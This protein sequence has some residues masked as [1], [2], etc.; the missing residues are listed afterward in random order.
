MYLRIRVLFLLSVMIALA[1]GAARAQTTLYWSGAAFDP[2]VGGAGTW[3]GTQQWSSSAGS[4]VAAAWTPGV[5]AV[6][7]GSSAGTISA[8]GSGV[9]GGTLTVQQNYTLDTAGQ[10]LVFGSLVFGGAA[11]NLTVAGG[12]GFSAAISSGTVTLAGA[13]TQLKIGST[14][15]LTGGTVVVQDSAK[16]TITGR[17]SVGGAVALQLLDAGSVSLLGGGL[18]VASLASSADSVIENGGSR[19]S[20]LTVALTS[21]TMTYAG[22]FRDSASGPQAIG[23][24]RLNKQGAG[25]LVLA[26]VA[27]TH[28]GGTMVSEGTLRMGAAGVLPSAGAVTLA[29][30]TLDLAGYDQSVAM[31]SSDMLGTGGQVLLGAG[32]LTIAA[33]GTLIDYRGTIAGTGG[34][35]KSGSGAQ[36]FSGNNSYSGGT[37][38]VAGTLS[39]GHASAL[40]SGSVTV[41]NGATLAIAT[42]STIARNLAL[43]SG[44][45]TL[46]NDPSTFSVTLSGVLSGAATAH[47]AGSSGGS[48]TVSGN[49]TYSGGTKVT[50]ATLTVAADSALG[51][52]AGGILLNNATLGW[53][54]A[55]NLAATRSLTVT[56]Y[57]SLALNG[58]ATTLAQNIGGTGSLSFGTTGTATLT[59]SNSFSGGL[60][61][62]TAT[63]AVDS[64][65]AL[66]AAAGT[67]VIGTSGTLRFRQS[68]NVPAARTIRTDGFVANL[69]V[70]AGATVVL[71]APLASNGGTSSVF[72]KQGA[73]T[74]DLAAISTRTGPT[75]VQAGTLRLSGGDNVLPVGRPL[76]VQSSGTL[77][78]A[79]HSQT[80]SSVSDYG[81]IA[82]GGG[83]FI[84]TGSSTFNGGFSGSGLVRTPGG[85]TYATGDWSNFTGRF[86]LEAGTLQVSTTLNAASTVAISSGAQ[87]KGTGTAGGVEVA[88]GGIV[89]PGYGVGTLRMQDLRVAG[90]ALYR[91]EMQSSDV[92]IAPVADRVRL[93]G[94][95]QLDST[96]GAPLV[97]QVQSLTPFGTAGVVAGFDPAQNYRFTLVTTTGGISGFTGS[98]VALDFS[99]FANAHPGM[100]RVELGNA[101]NDLELA[102]YATTFDTW[103]TQHFTAQ[104]L[105]DPAISGSNADPDGD[106]FVNLIEYALNLN[107]RSDSSVNAP[108]ATA[109]ATDWTFTYTRPADRPDLAYTVQRSTDLV[110]WS[111]AGVTS[112]LVST[113]DGIQ[114]WSAAYPISSSPVCF[115]RL[116]VTR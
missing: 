37:T 95:L 108:A 70:D 67:V 53:S 23:N 11:S 109:T 82:L 86:Q 34:V 76:T 15:S 116:A 60:N 40:G 73:G 111:S 57:S 72:Q 103:L 35:V 50:N 21:G 48:F 55:F 63:V 7:G 61:I 65:A 31:L 71:N 56:G 115:F 27:K 100:F 58:Q 43:E 92:G 19:A 54:G 93:S 33:G 85:G 36:K 110:N 79:G 29:S 39:V 38:V 89:N 84:V 105:A 107:P 18:T 6:L 30:G 106:G 113:S 5:N 1:S 44:E 91:W 62:S 98:N 80:V 99:S 22:V 114:T 96:S 20:V 13:G 81:T 9:A 42:N 10:D 4:Y 52:A 88:S 26:G 102:Y 28:T 49:N 2:A 47:F 74:L 25:T 66:G 45:V 24:L 32:T 16:L 83:T 17:S 68:V 46:T 12:G 90:G 77:D 14:G 3:N 59:G 64:D 8:G 41:K 104:E 78:L 87:I 101:G 112:S 69:A 94:A 51:D 97:V 75:T